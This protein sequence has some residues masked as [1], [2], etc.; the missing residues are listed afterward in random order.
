LIGVDT[1][2]FDATD[3]DFPSMTLSVATPYLLQETSMAFQ[4]RLPFLIFK[5]SEVTLQ[6]VT[7]RN[8]WLE[9]DGQLHDGKLRIMRK[10]ELVDSALQDIKQK[11]LDRRKNL[12]W[13]KLQND[14]GRLSKYALGGYGV[15]RGL[16][17][18]A[19]PE[20]FGKFYY[21]NP[22]CKECSYKEKCK[23]KKAEL[24]RG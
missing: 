8:L 20:C 19:R 2:R 16:D 5:T 6:G 22:V 11:A 4:S 17:W 18:L 1:K 15:Y 7:N 13:E 24:R 23:L 9:I 14:L 12:N 3:P 21:K 10:K